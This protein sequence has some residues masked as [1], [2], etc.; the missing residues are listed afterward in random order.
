MK[1][2]PPDRCVLSPDVALPMTATFVILNEETYRQAFPRIVLDCP[3]PITPWPE[4]ATGRLYFGLVRYWNFKEKVEP[5]TIAGRPYRRYRFEIPRTKTGYTAGDRAYPCEFTLWPGDL[6]PGEGPPLYLSA[7]WEDGRQE[8]RP[9]P[10]EVVRVPDDFQFQKLP[11]GLW[12]SPFDPDIRTYCRK[13]GVNAIAPALRDSD[14]AGPDVVLRE[15]RNRV[16]PDIGID[17]H[18]MSV[19]WGRTWKSEIAFTRLDG[20]QNTRFPWLS[21]RGPEWFEDARRA[22]ELVRKGF[23]GIYTDIE[24]EMFSGD[25]HEKTLARFQAFVKERYPKLVGRDPREFEKDPARHPEPHEAWVAFQGRLMSE[26]YL[27]LA[28]EMA[29]AARAVGRKTPPR[30]TIYNDARAGRAG[31]DLA[32]LAG[33]GDLGVD[34]LISP[35][36]YIPGP[37]AGDLARTCAKKYDRRFAPH[38][39]RAPDIPRFDMEEQ[40][41]EV[42]ANGAKGFHVWSR[43]SLDGRELAGPSRGLAVIRRVEDLILRSRLLDAPGDLSPQLRVRAVGD[44]DEKLILVTQYGKVTEPTVRFAIPTRRPARVIDLRTGQQVTRIQPE[45]NEVALTFDQPGIVLLHVQP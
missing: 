21:Y 31:A 29:K 13:L 28:E 42:F 25:F 34:V 9:V 15:A 40:V 2:I 37:G 17:L 36:I 43:T 22:G 35:P 30:L 27:G 32:Y 24:C 12:A 18:P 26:Y 3:E 44:G 14:C 39:G 20:T 19:F 10:L 41:Y 23:D 45:K 4:V 8:P 1:L 33:Q 6:A 5:I 16:G 38:L 11:A 7:E